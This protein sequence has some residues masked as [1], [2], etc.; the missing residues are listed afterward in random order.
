MAAQH[1]PCPHIAQVLL[2]GFLMAT[3]AAWGQDSLWVQGR[4]EPGQDS[5]NATLH[6][7]FSDTPP[8]AAMDT[9]WTRIG[10]NGGLTCWGEG[11]MGR[12]QIEQAWPRYR[13]SV[14]VT[15]MADSAG[16]ILVLATDTLM[17]RWTPSTGGCFPATPGS[18]IDR[19]L[20]QQEDVPFESRRHQAALAWISGQCLTAESLGR[21]LDTFDDEARRLSLLQAAPVVRPEA[22][23]T[24]SNRF[25]SSRYRAAFDG[26]LQQLP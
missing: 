26:W 23:H 22:L 16:L 2:L 5:L 3:S 8:P 18:A 21:L 1:P 15:L 9:T 25:F 20:A 6:W 14:M 17:Q 12:A 10:R 13:D 19:W 11:K 7:Q 4:I 24:L